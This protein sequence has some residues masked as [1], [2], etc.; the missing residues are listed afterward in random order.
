MPVAKEDALA[1]VPVVAID[2]AAVA[3]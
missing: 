2:F 1:M 3:P